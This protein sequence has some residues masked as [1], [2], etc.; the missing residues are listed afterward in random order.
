MA[1]PEAAR[2]LQ[3]NL[4]QLDAFG[5]THAGLVLAPRPEAE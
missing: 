3:A 5:T 4:R 2:V 1:S